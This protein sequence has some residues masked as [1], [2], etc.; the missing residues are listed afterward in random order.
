MNNNSIPPEV[1][2]NSHIPPLVPVNNNQNNN[3]NKSAQ[4]GDVSLA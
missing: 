4:T 2:S 3:D 1:D